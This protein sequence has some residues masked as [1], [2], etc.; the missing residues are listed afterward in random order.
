MQQEEIQRRGILK[1]V[2]E[3]IPLHDHDENSLEESSVAMRKHRVARSASTVMDPLIREEYDPSRS[4]FTLF[5]VGASTNLNSIRFRPKLVK[6][7]Q[8]NQEEVQCICVPEA[9][10]VLLRGTGF[11]SLPWLHPNRSALLMLLGVT[12]I[13]TVVVV[14]NKDGRRITDQGLGAI[15]KNDPAELLERWRRKESGLTMLQWAG[16][17]IS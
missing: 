12:Q 7:C 2:T 3:E 13:P 15:E 11:Y 16:C 5:F 6:F 4:E 17:T 14:S 8:S 1:L 10:D 9:D